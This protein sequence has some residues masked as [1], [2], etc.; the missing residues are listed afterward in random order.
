MIRQ[1]FRRNMHETDAQ[2]VQELK[3]A[4]E[5]SILCNLVGAR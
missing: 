1:Q 2:K 3:Q 5:N 4:Y